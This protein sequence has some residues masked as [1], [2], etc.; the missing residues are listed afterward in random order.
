MKLINVTSHRSS[1]WHKLFWLYVPF[2]IGVLVFAETNSLT[3]QNILRSIAI[4]QKGPVDKGDQQLRE[5][6]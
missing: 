5:N 6:L 3:A 4:I 1:V 2:R